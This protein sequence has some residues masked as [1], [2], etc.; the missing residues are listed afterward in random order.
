MEVCGQVPLRPLTS[1]PGQRQGAALIAHVDHPG[2]AAA[3]H[4]AT[5]HDAYQCLQGQL[6]QQAV[7]LRQ[8]RHLFHEVVVASPP[9]KACDTALELGPIGHV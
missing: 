1:P 8:K 3:A 6:P 2:D 4:D 7:R 9:G 5:I